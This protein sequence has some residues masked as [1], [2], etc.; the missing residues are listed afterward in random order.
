MPFIIVRGDITRLTADALVNAA[1]RNLKKGS[2]VCAAIFDAA[3]TADMQAACQKIG[4]CAVGAAVVTPAFRLNAKYVIHTVGPIWLGGFH[5]E[6]EQL[7]SCYQSALALA[8][9]LR[10][11]SIAFPLISSGVYGYPRESAFQVA[12]AEITS[13]LAAHDM[14]VYLSV[15]D[16]RATRPSPEIYAELLRAVDSPPSKPSGKPLGAL[17]DWELPDLDSMVFGESEKS[18][19]IG[20][21]ATENFSA[22]L[23]RL[24][25]ERGLTERELCRRANITPRELAA[26][27]NHPDARPSLSLALALAIALELTVSEAGNLLGLASL[28]L[29]SSRAGLIARW[30]MERGRFNIHE[31]NAALY[32]FDQPLLGAQP[33]SRKQADSDTKER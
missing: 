20:S 7:A 14:T 9:K 21:A 32:A 28:E 10:L 22:A 33:S 18:E 19:G 24:I 16:S 11:E 25:G 4:S 15:F 23:F 27:R 1:N 12:M 30:F 6:R 5:G 13:F 3:G 31:I 8:A 17:P 26:I 29:A 2:G